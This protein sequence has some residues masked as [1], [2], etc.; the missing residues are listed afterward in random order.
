MWK[1]RRKISRLFFVI[2]LFLLVSLSL[3]SIVHTCHHNA[4]G[5][6]C[7]ICYEINL[8]KNIF[9]NLLILSSLYVFVKQFENSSIPIKSFFKEKYYLTPV[10]LKVRL[11]E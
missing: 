3:I 11:L 4:I 8:M 1:N 10:L 5:E 6:D 2:F 7:T 9:E